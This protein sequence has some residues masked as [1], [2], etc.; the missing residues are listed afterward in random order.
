MTTDFRFRSVAWGAAF[1]RVVASL[2]NCR[3]PQTSCFPKVNRSPIASACAKL[4]MEG[5]PL[6]TK[7]ILSSDYFSPAWR[8][9]KLIPIRRF[10]HP[11]S[12]S[13][14]KSARGKRFLRGLG[15][16][17]GGWLRQRSGVRDRYLVLS[18]EAVFSHL[19]RGGGEG[20]PVGGVVEVIWWTW[21]GSNRR[22]PRQAGTRQH[23][24]ASNRSTFGSPDEI[25]NSSIVVRDGALPR[26]CRTPPGRP[27]PTVLYHVWIGSVRAG[28]L[29]IESRHPRPNRYRSVCWF[30]FPGC[31]RLAYRG[32][33]GP[34][35]DRTDDLPGTPGR[36][37]SFV[38]WW[39][40][41]GSNRRP[42]PCHG[43]ALP[44]CA[45]GPRL[46]G[47]LLYCRSLRPASQTRRPKDR[48]ALLR[49][50]YWTNR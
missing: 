1:A 14:N 20:Q 39:T 38:D 34:G 23:L 45:T 47:Q 7:G 50:T 6:K 49:A 11:G 25:S 26:L 44:N 32:I 8:P 43:S 21:S 33:G 28:A 19:E 2:A 35:R 9:A 5:K 27:V 46:A 22:P 17:L 41:S 42:L 30:G 3:W 24:S 16:T 13:Q 12:I 36:A 4:A 15:G 10:I 37:T 31:K 40:W 18:R 48:D 29:P